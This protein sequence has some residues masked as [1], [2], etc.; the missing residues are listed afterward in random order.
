VTECDGEEVMLSVEVW[1]GEWD[2]ENVGAPLEA[3]PPPTP[4]KFVPDGFRDSVPN[5][6]VE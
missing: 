5:A 2:G 6:V 1:V 4:I 3:L